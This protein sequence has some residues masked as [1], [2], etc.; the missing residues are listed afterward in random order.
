ME[1]IKLPAGEWKTAISAQSSILAAGVR[2][3]EL[4]VAHAN[5]LS[6]ECRQTP[7]GWCPLTVQEQRLPIRLA[8]RQ[9]RFG[10]LLVHVRAGVPAKAS[11]LPLSGHGSVSISPPPTGADLIGLLYDEADSLVTAT[12]LQPGIVAVSIFA[13]LNKALIGSPAITYAGIAADPENPPV[14]FARGS[15]L[16]LGVGPTLISRRQGQEGTTLHAPITAITGSHPPAA[17]RIVAACE[18][19]AVILWGESARSPESSFAMDLLHP[20]V[21]LSR[22]GVLVATTSDTIEVHH[23][24][25]GRLAFLATLPGPG[26]P[27]I[28][29]LPTDAPRRFALVTQG[30]RV[31]V[32]EAA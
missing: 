11:E 23:T 32:Y 2:G 10:E 22:G 24:D 15:Y 16:Y 7:S 20:V 5:L 30:G 19:G 14:F 6:G 1:E 26:S 18:Q 13:V 17:P 28:A 21:G 29:V 27:P 8:A 4:V 25:G 9:H 12:V 31:L 3:G